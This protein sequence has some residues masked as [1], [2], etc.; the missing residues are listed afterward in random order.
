MGTGVPRCGLESG[1]MTATALRPH[2]RMLW[3]GFRGQSAYRAALI[4]GIATNTTFGLLRG[5]ILL[6]TV[7]AAGGDLGGYHLLAMSSYVWWSQ[8]L[9]GAINVWGRSQLAVRIRTG[10]VVV[11]MLRPL[12]LQAAIIWREVGAG[13]FTLL[14]RGVPILLVGAL[15]VGMAPPATVG[16]WLLAPLSLVCAVALSS[17]VAYAVGCAGFWL[18]ETRGV[19][20][21]VGVSCGFLAGLY[22]PL[23][24]FPH[25]LRI[26]AACTPFPSMLMSFT[27][28]AGGAAQTPEALRLVGV[29]AAWLTAM[30]L[31]GR[32]LT[33]LGTRRLEVQGG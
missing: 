27:R 26:V 8:A 30:L 11:D 29:Q 18:V 25:W 33:R 15:T 2:L 28:I 6:A 17:A 9:L 10:D 32:L 23:A 24:L 7:R 21:L 13:L 20:M 4:A 19:Q 14:P 16:C 1:A 3:S 31:L 5:S 12:D 22:V